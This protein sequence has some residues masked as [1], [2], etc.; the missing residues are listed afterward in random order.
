MTWDA[1][2]LQLV[3]GC[4]HMQDTGLKRF[5]HKPAPLQVTW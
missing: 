1:L 5:A 3:D 2:S 4:G